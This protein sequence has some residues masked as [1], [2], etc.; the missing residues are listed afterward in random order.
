MQHFSSVSSAKNI[1]ET[2][3]FIQRKWTNLSITKIPYRKHFKR[4]YERYKKSSLTL[5][6]Y[7]I[8][9]FIAYKM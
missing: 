4:H 8:I 7:L 5:N 3:M 9:F 1:N 2:R 6:M